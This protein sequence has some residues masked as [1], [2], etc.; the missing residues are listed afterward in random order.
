[1]KE[2]LDHVGAEAAGANDADR[3]GSNRPL[4]L[5][6]QSADLAVEALARRSR[7]AAGRLA[8][9][10]DVRLRRLGGARH[11]QARSLAPGGKDSGRDRHR[12]PRLELRD[13]HFLPIVV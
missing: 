2:L 1:M 5:A 12:G 3:K 7:S 13:D 10:L 11:V 4:P 8:Y 6:G 9:A